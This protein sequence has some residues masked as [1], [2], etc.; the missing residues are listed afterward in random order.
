MPRVRFIVKGEVQ[1]VGFRHF[2]RLEAERLSLTGYVKNR[3]DG[4]VEIEVQGDSL[5]L[6]EFEDSIHI[7]PQQA[8]VTEVIKTD[9]PEKIE[10]RFMVSF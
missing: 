1:G 6:E 3:I 2:V 4:S 8:D 10:I 7:G 5:A 9:I